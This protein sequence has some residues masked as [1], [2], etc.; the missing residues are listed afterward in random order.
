MAFLKDELSG[1]VPTETATE[2]Q[3]LVA[4]GSTVLRLGKT[5]PMTTEK[6]KVPMLTDGPGA[7]WVGEG[8]RIQTSKATW[9]FPELTAKKLAVIIPVT[10]EKLEDA[11]VD[12]FEELK[13]VIAEAFYTAIDAAALFG[14][15]SPFAKNV[16]AVAEAAENVI[17]DGTNKSLDLDVSDTMAIVEINCDVNGFAAHYGIKNALRKLRDNNGN[18][19]YVPDTD[20]DKMYSEPIEFSRNNAWDKSKAELIAGDWDKLLVGVKDDIEY[21]IL[22]EATLQNTLDAD[23]KPLSLAE[24]DMVAIKATMRI[25]VLPIKD[26]AFAVLVPAE[27][28]AGTAGDDNSGDEEGTV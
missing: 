6:K 11:T 14:T 24:Q 9:I 2:I 20:T 23:G 10:R 8:E 18:A 26:D 13:P 27:Y 5:I 4:R 28:N 12:V 7:Y 21:E 16:F 17:V 22:K 15:A 19:L 3:G 1:F 25:A